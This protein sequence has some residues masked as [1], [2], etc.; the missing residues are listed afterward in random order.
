MSTSPSIE[1]QKKIPKQ[2][3]ITHGNFTQLDPI[4]VS[5]FMKGEKRTGL[6][7]CFPLMTLAL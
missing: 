7:K 4:I 3:A 6:K 5:I 1:S 2:R